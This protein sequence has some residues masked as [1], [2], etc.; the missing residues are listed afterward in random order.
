VRRHPRHYGGPPFVLAKVLLCRRVAS[1]LS[2]V[3]VA[4]SREQRERVGAFVGGG[5]RP[6]AGRGSGGRGLR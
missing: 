4:Q 1:P 2:A 6:G 5:A 3:A